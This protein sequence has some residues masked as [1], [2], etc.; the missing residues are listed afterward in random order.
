MPSFSEKIKVGIQDMNVYASV[1]S[2]SGPFPAVVV[3]QHGSGVD[4][5]VREYC[6]RLAGEGYAAVA[7]DLFHRITDDMV[8][9]GSSKGS[10]LDDPEIIYDVNTTVD[11]LRT[12]RAIDTERLGITGFCLGGR[13]TWLMA[14]ATRHFKAAVPHWGGNI[15]VP[16][17]KAT[18]SPFARTAEINCPILFHFGAID[19]NPSQEDMKKLDAELKKYN[20]P[21]QFFTYP[22]SDHGFGNPYGNRYN[23]AAAD[24]AWPRTLEF[25]ATHLKRVPVRR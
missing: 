9:D 23:K 16:R 13:V 10:H 11:W 12:H 1:P 14:A 7:P 2:G 6:D 22:D 24:A 15:M 21:H 25:F 17:G 20:K 18:Q 19:Q 8:K 4:R 5:F 3:I